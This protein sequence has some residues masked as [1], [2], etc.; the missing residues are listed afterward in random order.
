MEK[1]LEQDFFERHVAEVAYDLIGKVLLWNGIRLLITET[2]AYRAIDDEASHAF[3]GPTPRTQVMF[4]PPGIS[5]VYLIYGIYHSLNIVTEPEVFASA[6]LIRTVKD[7]SHNL[8]ISGPG[9]VCKHLNITRKNNGINLLD[10][11]LYGVIDNN[12]IPNLVTTPRI[13]ITKNKEI[14]WRFLMK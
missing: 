2:E 4:G 7:L 9:K 10:E 5:Y 3:K 1:R 6:V 13:G 11:S 14:L 12:T 8:L